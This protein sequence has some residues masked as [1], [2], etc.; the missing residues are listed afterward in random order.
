MA[1]KKDPNQQVTRTDLAPAVP[2]MNISPLNPAPL[3][4]TET[5]GFTDPTKWTTT[6]GNSNAPSSTPTNDFIN[7]QT[8]QPSS[9]QLPDGRVLMG[10]DPQTIREIANREAGKRENIAIQSEGSNIIAQQQ[11]MQEG[12]QL[13]GEVGQIN[14]QQQQAGSLDIGQAAGVAG[15]GAAGGIATGLATGALVGAGIGAAGGPAAP[16][17]I[18]IGAALGAITGIV[19]GFISNLRKQKNENIQASYSNLARS[20]R[21]LRAIVTDTNGGGSAASN[22]DLFNSQLT[23]IDEAY[24]RLQLENRGKFLGA[25]ATTQLENMENFYS[26]GGSRELLI[27]EMQQAIL[28]PNANKVLVTMEDFAE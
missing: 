7:P 12:K 4:V 2:Q 10:L 21:N 13:V 27:R 20:T 3:Q 8:G 22:I 9:Y 6:N 23:L 28:N 24:S 17:T 18:P 26:V 15:L 16:L 25:D 1:K 19:T 5:H 11:K 14:P